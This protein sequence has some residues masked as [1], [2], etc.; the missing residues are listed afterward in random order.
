MAFICERESNPPVKISTYAISRYNQ[1]L[2]RGWALL[3]WTADPG[4]FVCVYQQ[5][6]R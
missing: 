4:S 5:G 2:Y 6:N 3:S 1:F